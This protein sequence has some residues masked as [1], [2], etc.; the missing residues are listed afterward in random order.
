MPRVFTYIR[1]AFMSV[2]AGLYRKYKKKHHHGMAIFPVPLFKKKNA[3]A[4][5]SYLNTMVVA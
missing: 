4:C 1:K 3:L 5:Q 2:A